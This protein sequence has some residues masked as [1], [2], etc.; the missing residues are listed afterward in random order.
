VSSL[1]ISYAG[2]DALS[3]NPVAGDRFVGCSAQNRDGDTVINI[4]VNVPR[5]RSRSSFSGE[6]LSNA[7]SAIIF[8]I[9]RH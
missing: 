3:S 6:G 9:A 4:I 8:Y 1:P 7:K 2:A 5:D